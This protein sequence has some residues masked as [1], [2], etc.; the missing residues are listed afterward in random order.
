MYRIGASTPREI[1]EEMFKEYSEASVYQMEV[2]VNKELSEALDFDKLKEW[3][4]K[5][6]VCLY[7]FH[8]PFMPFKDIDISRDDLAEASIEY[9][10]QY[11]DKGTSVGIDKYVIHPSG[12]PIAEEDRPKRMERAKKSL[13]ELCEYASAKNAVICVENLPRTCLGR[14]SADILDLISVND[15]L[16]VC[17]DT[18]HL[19][20]EDPCEFIKRVGA[21]I[22][23]MHVSDY[24]FKDE[25]HWLPGEGMLDWQGILAAIKEIGY[26]GAWLYEINLE[27]PWTIVRP[28]DLTYKD[29][30]KNAKE[31]FENKEL[32]NISTPVDGLK[33]W[34]E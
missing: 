9:L 6:G 33:K 3:S 12:E 31:L 16:M 18:N 14:D 30:Y 11:I 21:K 20:A 2:S 22:V 32:T 10:K 24:D 19:L 4:E 27:A 7:S 29:F 26:S 13:N 28:R 23:T 34:N 25:R 1:T 17:F 15:K 8:L 5:Y